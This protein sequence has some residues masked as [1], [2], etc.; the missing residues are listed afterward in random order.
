VGGG[1]RVEGVVE[2]YVE[3]SCV[4]TGPI[5]SLEKEMM[6]QVCRV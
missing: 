1:G 2:A 5:L 6:E 4:P 3:K